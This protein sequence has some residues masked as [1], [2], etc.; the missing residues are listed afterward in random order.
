MPSRSDLFLRLLADLRVVHDAGDR[1]RVDQLEHSLQMA[2]RA[3]RAGADDELVVVALLHDVFRV[4]APAAHGPALALA[5]SDRL[6]RDRVE[7]LAHHSA[8]QHDAV[9]GS[10]QV[11]EFHGESWWVDACRFGAW[12]AASF[13]PGYDTLPLTVFTERVR[14]LLD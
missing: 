9:H 1:G 2:T 14:A 8:W 13:S 4:L 10:E 3:D 11:L 12:D 5:L 6:T 7:I